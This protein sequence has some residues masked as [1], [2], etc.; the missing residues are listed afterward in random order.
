MRLFVV[1][2]EEAPGQTGIRAI[3]EGDDVFASCFVHRRT[4]ATP[5]FNYDPSDL[6]VVVVTSETSPVVGVLEWLTD[7]PAAV[8]VFVVLPGDVGDTLLKITS[9]IADDFIVLPFGPAELRHRIRRLMAQPPEE[10]EAVRQRLIDEMGLSKLVGRDPAFVK[11]ISQLPRFARADMPVCI[12]GE[13]GTGKELCARALH[14]LSRRQCFPFIAVDCGALPEQLFENEIFGHARGAFTDAHRDQ[15]GLIAMAEGGTLFLDEID[16]LSLPAQAKLLRF[17]QEH[18]FRALG[19]DRFDRANVR[20]I[21]ATNRDL[22]NVV[23]DRQF[24]SD[25]YFRL[26]VLRLRLPPLRERSGD[27]QLLAFAALKECQATDDSV[28]RSFSPAS[29]RMLAAYGWPG[30]VRELYNVVQR[31]VVA[32]DSDCILPHHLE[33]SA[34]DLP[35]RMPAEC[36]FR[37]E[38]SAVVEAFERRYVEELLRK[39]R[40]NV[41]HAAREAQQDRRAFG[42]FIK[43]YN[44]DRL[45]LTA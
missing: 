33:L 37:S 23:R 30:N 24:R 6:V 1:D 35:P 32:C 42:R 34:N 3:L 25:L 36:A 38:R 18:T 20:V 17:L 4:L 16:A 2:G 10:V 40:G 45:S 7:H 43:K 27:I 28:A 29:L 44:I 26:N 41:T 5:D 11:A 8:P 13:T 22:E 14:H 19:S 9:R 31:A 39:H 21:T 12:T 15:K